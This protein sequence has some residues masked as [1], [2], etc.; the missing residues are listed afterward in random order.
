MK[1]IVPLFQTYY[2]QLIERQLKK[3]KAASRHR[4]GF[5]RDWESRHKTAD[6]TANWKTGNEVALLSLI[7]KA[8]NRK[9]DIESFENFYQPN[10]LAKKGQLG[11]VSFV[12]NISANMWEVDKVSNNCLWNVQFDLFDL[13]V[14]QVSISGSNY[15]RT[16]YHAQRLW[17]LM[18]NDWVFYPTITTHN[19][20][21]QTA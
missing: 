4:R 1:P 18:T 19:Y 7:A 20:R 10:V 8:W 3:S 9:R 12:A 6:L 11:R 21:K 2:F 14:S 5:S 16:I 17:L 13:S 15:R